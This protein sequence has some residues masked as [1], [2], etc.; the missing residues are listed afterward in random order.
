MQQMFSHHNLLN[1][2]VNFI[3][4]QWATV[5]SLRLC[6]YLKKTVC[7]ERFLIISRKGSKVPFYYQILRY[8]YSFNILQMHHFPH[9]TSECSAFW[10]YNSAFPSLCSFLTSTVHK[11]SDVSGGHDLVAAQIVSNLAPDGHDDGHDEVGKCR[12]YAHLDEREKIYF[13]DQLWDL[14]GQPE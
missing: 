5:K 8:Y 1:T 3:I 2:V 6:P 4:S 11:F 13:H 10:H 7:L 12:N 14:C 9:T